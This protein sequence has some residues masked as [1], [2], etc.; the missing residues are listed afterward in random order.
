MMIKIPSFFM[1]IFCSCKI[2]TAV[3]CCC[4]YRQDFYWICGLQRFLPSW[5]TSLVTQMVK[6]LPAKQET[7]VWCWGQ[8]YTWRRE[9]LPTPV[10]LPGEFYGQ[11]SL[12]CYHP[13]DFKSQT[14]L[15]NCHFHYLH[16]LCSPKNPKHWVVAPKYSR[17]TEWV[18][19]RLINFIKV[20]QLIRVIVKIQKSLLS[21]WIN[22][23]IISTL[24]LLSFPLSFFSYHLPA[25][26]YL[27]S[28]FKAPWFSWWLR[29]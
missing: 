15:S 12:A 2:N 7:W 22:E 16:Y 18:L 5:G 6:I 10:F 14:R 9:W 29:W 19:E 17:C 27:I 23:W 26:L 13:W 21:T 28:I 11:R 3:C 25:F 24:V 20:T 8:E 1:P 4:W